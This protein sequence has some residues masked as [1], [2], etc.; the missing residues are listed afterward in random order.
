[1]IRAAHEEGEKLLVYVDETRPVLQGARLTARELM[2]EGI[3]DFLI[4][5][6]LIYAW[7]DW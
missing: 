3:P 5:I 1:V 2:K 4:N 6:F 7:F